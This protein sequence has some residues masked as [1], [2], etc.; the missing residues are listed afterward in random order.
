MKWSNVL[1]IFFGMV[2]PVD[3]LI[4]RD[5]SCRER[6]I[7]PWDDAYPVEFLAAGL[8]EWARQEREYAQ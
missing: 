7:W 1:P 6:V 2:A 8:C 3:G 4:V 5:A